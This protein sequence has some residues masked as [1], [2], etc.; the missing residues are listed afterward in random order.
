MSL[1]PP[2]YVAHN[3]QCSL[4]KGDRV[5]RARQPVLIEFMIYLITLSR[6]T[7]LEISSSA[8]KPKTTHFC[9]IYKKFY[10]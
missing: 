8:Q 6:K 7:D 2:Q 5:S 4:R 1:I 10:T 9:V 3:N